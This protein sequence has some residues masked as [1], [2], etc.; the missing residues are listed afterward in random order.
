MSSKRIAAQV[1]ANERWAR[2]DDRSAATAP[3]RTG[4]L[5]KFELIVDP[6]GVLNE[7]ERAKRAANAL[8]AHMARLRASSVKSR[9]GSAAS[10]EGARP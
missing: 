8:R 1:A 3:A 4:F 10:G 2:V 9:S 7:S 6:D 5:K